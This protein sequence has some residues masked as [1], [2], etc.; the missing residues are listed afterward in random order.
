MKRSLV[1]LLLL[2]VAG[3]SE[4]AEM[5]AK[6][7][8]ERLARIER[9]KERRAMLKD[10]RIRIGMSHREFAR[11]WERP[12][13]TWIDRSTSRYGITEWWW[14]DYDCEPTRPGS[15]GSRY[16][17]CFENGILDYWAEN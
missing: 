3:C 10:G 13:H 14:F 6:A 16:A 15:L 7:E 17:F 8:E 4:W 9:T 1:I 2:I 11:L 5:E 12:H